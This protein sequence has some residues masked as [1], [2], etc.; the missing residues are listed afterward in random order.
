MIMKKSILFKII[1]ITVF[2]FGLSENHLFGQTTV[3]LSDYNWNSASTG[4]GSVHKDKSV[5]NNTL[6]IGGVTYT[7]GIGTH[8]YSEIVYSLN[9]ISG[10]GWKTFQAVIGR[11]DEADNCNCG[12]QNIIFAVEIDGVRTQYIHYGVNQGGQSISINVEGK[13]TLKLIVDDAGDQYWGDHGDWA[14]AKL[15]KV[16]SNP[17]TSV[18]LSDY[19][20]NSASTGWGSV[21]KDKSVD[22]NTLTIGGVTYAKGIGTHAYSVIEYNLNNISGGG[23]KTFQAIIGRDDEADGCNCGSQNIVF[24]V[25][26]DGVRTQF[27]HYGV[28][29]SGQQISIN[30]E[31]KSTLKLIVEDAGDQYWGDHGDWADAK[32]SKDGGYTPIQYQSVQLAQECVGGVNSN[33]NGQSTSTAGGVK[34]SVFPQ[35]ATSPN[36]YSVGWQAN[37]VATNQAPANNV[38]IEAINGGSFYFKSNGL[39]GGFDPTY[40]SFNRFGNANITVSRT[41][42]VYQLNN[43]WSGRCDHPG[44]TSTGIENPDCPVNNRFVIVKDL[45]GN[46][47][48]SFNVGDVITVE[49]K[50]INT[51]NPISY[52]MSSIYFTTGLGICSATDANKNKYQCA[53]AAIPFAIQLQPDRNDGVS[54]TD[55]YGTCHGWTR[56][57]Y[58]GAPGQNARISAFNESN[59]QE[60]EEKQGIFIAPNPVNNILHY[61]YISDS[62][63]DEI[64]LQIFDMTGRSVKSLKLQKTGRITKGEIS[65]ENFMQ[66][67]YILNATDGIRKD[68]KRFI[69]E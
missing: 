63:T 24:A 8:A 37:T 13:S 26:I 3:Y 57:Y 55:L 39:G 6:R 40:G 64:Q 43:I 32:L 69:K 35:D 38:V 48:K 47:K 19:N 11:D 36:E 34:I 12:S 61:S 65:V 7:K 27:I 14:D 31:G 23:W 45:A 20:W 2:A 10:G 62:E 52:K 68:A 54:N 22:N 67:S 41:N 44:S 5:D 49:L 21:H 33:N 59:S 50:T 29:Q 53:V 25:E 4:W 30:V 9:N 60:S 66:G 56:Y 51:N 16:N 15:S 58:F 42:L 28:N 46:T 18:Y 17:G 1:V